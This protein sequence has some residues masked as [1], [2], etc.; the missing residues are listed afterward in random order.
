MRQSCSID[1]LLA[2]ADAAAALNAACT[3]R[4]DW[5]W[6]RQKSAQIQ[7]AVLGFAAGCSH[8][9]SV[10]RPAVHHRALCFHPFDHSS[11][12][13]SY[14]LHQ[15]AAR[16]PSIPARN[17]A[18]ARVS[19]AQCATRQVLHLAQRSRGRLTDTCSMF[20]SLHAPC[21]VTAMSLIRA[22]YPSFS[23]TIAEFQRFSCSRRVDPAGHSAPWKPS[24]TADASIA[25]IRALG[26]S[27][28]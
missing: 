17:G 18:T 1:K 10:W 11:L 13:P 9:S 16:I 27:K 14:S 20:L 4:P 12:D 5:R 28:T 15:F 8:A 25:E 3:A 22:A 6:Q 19:S 7:R 24:T 26:Q 2:I 21:E 23:I